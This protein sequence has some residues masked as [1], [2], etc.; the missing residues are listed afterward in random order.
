MNKTFFFYR[1]ELLSSINGI[2]S[3]IF[4]SHSLVV[5]IGLIGVFISSVYYFVL[6]FKKNKITATSIIYCILLL[7][8]PLF[9]QF[10]YSNLREVSENLFMIQSPIMQQ[11]R[12]RYCQIDI[13]QNFEGRFCK[14]PIFVELVHRNVPKNS[15]IYIEAGAEKS[16][17]EFQLIE[18]YTLVSKPEKANYFLLYHSLENHNLTNDGRLY[19]F[20]L[21]Q[22]LDNLGTENFLGFFK[23]KKQINQQMV[24]F[25]NTKL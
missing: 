7:W 21:D 9:I 19:R 16:F 13:V 4:L 24:I 11:L 6:Y 20:G 23:V 14:I 15:L 10:F 18:E 3:P 12:W 25:E 1:P 8:F 2:L 22:P 17:L 5:E